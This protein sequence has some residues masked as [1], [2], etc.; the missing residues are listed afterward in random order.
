VD[1]QPFAAQ[2]ERLIEATDYLGSPFSSEDK[3][4]V[5]KLIAAGNTKDSSSKLQGILDRRCLFGVQINPEMRV[6]VIQGAAKPELVE[7]GWR[8]FLVKV[9][10]ESGTTADL[11]ALSPSA[12]SLFEP[13]N[14]AS[15]KALQRASKPNLDDR[16]LELQMFNSQPLRSQ[17]SGLALDYRIVQLYSRDPGKREA[18]ISFNVG[19]GTQDLGFRNETDTL[20]DCLPAQEV[21]LKVLDERGSPAT[22]SFLIRDAQQRVYPALSKRLA[23]DFGFHPQIYRSD[24][25]I[26]RLPR[27]DYSVVFSR[28][29]ESIAQES[30]ISVT[31]AR[32]TNNFKVARWI[33]PSTFGWWSGDHH[34]HAAGCAHYVKPTEGVLAQD[35]IRHCMGEDLKIG[36]NLTWG[37]CFDYQKQ[38]FCGTIDKVSQYP[39]LL[40]YD[41]EVPVSVRTNRVTFVCCV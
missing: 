24:G 7:Q 5:R 36:A 19:Q 12:V 40:R 16:W 18:R 41:I 39:Y 37:P 33:D 14:T 6:K 30:K 25:E 15:D 28:G 9:Q 8:I 27:G 13:A 23:P 21:V 10:N 26:V 4:A 38:F 1:W 29:P 3:A 31:E 22:A 34:I 11:R 17:L 35:M 32:Q 2:I 20:F